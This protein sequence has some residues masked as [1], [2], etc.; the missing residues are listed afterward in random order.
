MHVGAVLSED[1]IHIYIYNI[2]LCF[3]FQEKL[4]MF[5]KNGNL[6]RG[7]NIRNAYVALHIFLE[8]L[9]PGRKIGRK[10][11]CAKKKSGKWRNLGTK[12]L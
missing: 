6:T 5:A 3:F 7:R 11:K 10:K 9:L 12:I 4:E 8:K 2:F 1:V